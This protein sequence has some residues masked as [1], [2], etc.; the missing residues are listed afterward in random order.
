VDFVSLTRARPLALTL[1]LL[2]LLARNSLA[3]PVA[4]RGVAVDETLEGEAVLAEAL[5]EAPLRAQG[6]PVFARVRVDHAELEPAPGDFR[7]D[8][9]D[10]RLERYKMKGVPV[11]LALRGPLPGVADVEVW[12]R[13]VRALVE[14]CR[15]AVVGYELGEMPDSGPAPA[16]KDFAFAVKLTAVQV[17][18]ADPEASFLQGSLRGEDLAWQESLYGEDVAPYVD[19][20]VLSASA[21]GSGDALRRLQALVEREDPTASI[22]VSGLAL[23]PDPAAAARSLLTWQLDRLGSRVALTSYVGSVAALAGALRAVD[24]V[25]DVLTSEIVPLEDGAARL[26]L[27][28][29]GEDV[30]ASLPH[31]LLYNL[32]T[33]STYLVYR[34]APGA[35][36]RLAVELGDPTGRKPILRDAL[37]AKRGPL[38]GFTWDRSANVTRVDVPL[39][40]RPL[41]VDFNYGEDAVPAARTEVT[42]RVLPTVGEVVFRH[43]QAQ[44]AQDARLRSYV[45]NARIENHFRPNATDSGFDVVTENRF[46]SDKD[47][48]EWEETSFTLNGS[49]WGKNRPPFPLLQPEKVLSLPLDLRLTRDYRYRLA[50]VEQVGGRECYAVRFEPLSEGHSL[51]RGT[52]WLDSQSF[53]K[54]KVQAVQTQLEAPVVSNEEIQLFTPEATVEGLPL[55]LMSRFTSRQIMLIAGRNLLVERMAQFSAFEVNAPD[56]AARRLAA[57]AG[58]NIMYRDTDQG[59]RY[60][61]KRGQERVVQERPVTSAKA[62]ALGATFDPSYDFPLPIVGINYLD[63]NFLGKDRQLALLFGGVLVLANVQQP[64]AIGNKVD[65]SVD[66]FA[67]AVAANDQVF[68][69]DGERLDERLKSRPFSTGINMGYQLTPFQKLIGSYQFRFDAYERAEQTAPDFEP[70]VDTVTNGF[71]LGYE[72]RRGGYSLVL[73]GAL[74]RRGSWR[75][76]GTGEEYDPDQRSYQK[77]SASLSKDVFFKAIHKVHLNAAYF[78][79]HHL[80]RFS[81][82]QFGMFDENK[83]RG[84]PSAGVRF[85]ELSMFRGSY[86]LNLFDLYR[87]DLFFDQALGRTGEKGSKWE[88]ITGLGLGLNFKAPFGTLVRGEIGKSFLP[89]AYRGSGSVVGQI[90]VL[91]PL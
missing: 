9:L 21:Q 3:V 27:A 39:E 72:Y 56:F 53:V 43:Q 13:F 44:A 10:A 88:S 38:A 65:L 55:Y 58:D 28:V 35:S 30:T 45:A 60:L 15:G 14:H 48:T 91:K 78:G 42:A 18:S 67:I 47:V 32:D 70:P 7:F 52:V 1:P 77:Y 31:V 26:K 36:G 17:R 11:L 57:R 66:L 87:L 6:L 90:L 33:F 22:V 34:G 46:F 40:E 16:V 2:L 4:L 49:R 61:V 84:V 69:A 23:E 12:R 85:G 63:F 83:I 37:S 41:L 62:L 86:S 81:K 19:A 76:W 59:L 50:G 20:V 64:K 29:G 74:Y 5:N 82:Y 79:G 71:G 24:Q 25:K 73:G 54:L 80:D 89:E 75:S 8:R 51:Y 68:D